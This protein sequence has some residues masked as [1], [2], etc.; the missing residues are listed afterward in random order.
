[1]NR[2]KELVK[3][4]LIISIGKFSTKI[5]QF[6]LL[7][8]YTSI[9]TT[10]Q[11]G[12]YDLL[13]II[14]IFLIP[15]IT[16]QMDEGM[17]RFLIEAKTDKDKRDVFSHTIIFTVISSILWSLIIFVVGSLL[18]YQYTIWLIVSPIAYLFR[19]LSYFLAMLA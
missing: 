11:Y 16:L 12:E 1:M 13:N 19:L 7:P 15:I 18:N 2:K 10:S 17:F 4:T 9:L 6:L 3:N 8:L 14:S 5:V